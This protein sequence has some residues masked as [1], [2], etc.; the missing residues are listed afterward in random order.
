MMRQPYG[1]NKIVARADKPEELFA[2]SSYCAP[3]L[4]VK[5]K[6]LQ[7]QLSNFDDLKNEIISDINRAIMDASIY[8]IFDAI[9]VDFFL[10][11]GKIFHDNSWRPAH[12]FETF[13]SRVIEIEGPIVI[14]VGNFA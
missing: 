8:V 4:S 6:N 2:G 14:T 12:N 5:L 9:D 3:C 13:K 1:A 11:V 7:S 10:P